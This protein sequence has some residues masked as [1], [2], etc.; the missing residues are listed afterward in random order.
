M[1]RTLLPDIYIKHFPKFVFI[2]RKLSHSHTPEDQRKHTT[3]IAP[4]VSNIRAGEWSVEL[5]LKLLHPEGL[6][7]FQDFVIFFVLQHFLFSSC[8]VLFV[9][10]MVVVIK[11]ETEKWPRTHHISRQDGGMRTGL[12]SE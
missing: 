2:H 6:C 8:T 10:V 12:V 7:S 11:P 5:K 9:V 4:V 1:N 3:N